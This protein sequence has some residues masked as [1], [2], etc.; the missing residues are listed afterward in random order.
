MNLD[1]SDN[2]IKEK[3]PEHASKLLFLTHL[4]ITITKGLSTELVE[5]CSDVT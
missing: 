4:N 3:G 2:E 5:N 1:I